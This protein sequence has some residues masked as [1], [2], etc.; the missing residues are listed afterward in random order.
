MTV[1]PTLWDLLGLMHILNVFEGA[2][3][4]CSPQNDGHKNV[5]NPKH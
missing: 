1:K 2:F 5:L 4:I 3:S